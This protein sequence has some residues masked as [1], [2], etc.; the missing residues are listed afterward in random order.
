[1]SAARR[2]SASRS[3]RLHNF[4]PTDEEAAGIWDTVEDNKRFQR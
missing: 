3:A 1:M 4:D 2:R